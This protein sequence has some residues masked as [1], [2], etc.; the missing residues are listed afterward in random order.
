M[1]DDTELLRSFCTDR[2][3]EA[4]AELVRRNLS[5]VYAVALR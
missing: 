3:E 5:L 1:I 2:S 4:F